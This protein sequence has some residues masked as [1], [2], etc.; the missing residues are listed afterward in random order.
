MSQNFRF[1]RQALLDN[2]LLFW[3]VLIVFSLI[4]EQRLEVPAW[5]Q[6]A[7]RMHPLI[8]HFPIVIVLFSAGV[9][10]VKHRALPKEFS[11]IL[12]QVS[13]H[14]MALTVLTGILL[15]QEDY[16][17]NT[18]VLHQWWAIAGLGFTLFLHYAQVA[19]LRLKRGLGMVVVI[20]IILTGHFGATLT[21]GE[22]FV[23]GPLADPIE[24][25][26]WNENDL[27]FNQLIQPVL[28]AKCVSCHRAGKTKG[29]LRLDNLEGFKKGG[30]SGPIFVLGDSASSLLADRIHLP[31][32]E[33][34]HMPPKN[35][36]QLSTDE[37]ELLELWL[38]S[39]LSA[40]SKIAEL[41]PQHPLRKLL[42]QQPGI[43]NY[44]FQPADVDAIAELNNFFRRVAPLYPDSPALEAAYYSA[45]NF[46]VSSIREL[47]GISEQ[48]VR[49]QLN[50]MPLNHVDLSVLADFPNLEELRLNFTDLADDQ[51]K[52]LIPLKSL[53]TLALS[54]NPIS[55]NQIDELAKFTQIRELYFWQ[56]SWDSVS[57]KKLQAKLPSTKIAFGFDA[58]AVTYA[59]NAPVVEVDT[60]IFKDSTFVHLEHP[61]QGTEI[62]YTLD[63]KEPDSIRSSKYEGPFSIFS[64]ASIKARAFAKGWYGSETAENLAFKSGIRPKEKK[65]IHPPNRYYAGKGV[66]TLFDGVKSPLSHISGAWLGYTDEAFDLEMKLEKEQRPKE[67]SLSV[68]YHEGAYIM[69]PDRF[70]IWVGNGDAWTK[71]PDPQVPKSNEISAI[72]YGILSSTLPDTA[73]DRIR[74][75]LQPVQKLP[76]WHPGAG[77]KGWVFV[78]EILI[79]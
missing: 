31:L 67:I 77:A 70:E 13:A 14:F 58:G 50:R 53:K 29:E 18:A 34:E 48:L 3:I 30:E 74:V 37:L 65:L 63:G 51:L 72:R 2:L 60:V 22:N 5:L 25:S 21:H 61:I 24:K 17:G 44:N 40:D 78:D 59:L 42:E 49:L 15:K 62:R 75:R 64:S 38:A 66:E 73:F 12:W 47:K 11:V 9:L 76:K 52:Y 69:P 32:S 79:N 36:P 45:G 4:F 7:G 8:L 56:P 33:K 19:S 26:D 39:N 20:S 23:S 46:E 54:G 16:E 27:V 43:E 68:L 55:E 28:D 71:L 10:F 35:K 57:R 1:S 6:V 41:N